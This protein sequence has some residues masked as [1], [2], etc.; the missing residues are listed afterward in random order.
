MKGIL[1][2][3]HNFTLKLQSKQVKLCS[4]CSGFIVGYLLW[5]MIYILFHD[6]QIF[7]AS[8]STFQLLASGFLLSLPSSITWLAQRMGLFHSDNFTRFITSTVLMSG[9]VIMVFQP[10][11]KLLIAFPLA[12]FWGVIVIFTGKSRRTE[13]RQYSCESCLQSSLILKFK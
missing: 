2:H 12:F 6:F 10:W 7:I 11:S 9:L 1:E 13:N 8:I 5:I 4:R 3:N